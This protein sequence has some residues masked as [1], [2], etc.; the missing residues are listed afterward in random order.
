[1]INMKKIFINIS[2]FIFISVLFSFLYY[3][4]HQDEIVLSQDFSFI[5]Y[6]L[7][8]ASSVF[9]APLL[10]KFFNQLFK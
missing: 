7:I 5:I 3:L 4:T 10:Q 8:G 9:F 1:M 6:S 2:V